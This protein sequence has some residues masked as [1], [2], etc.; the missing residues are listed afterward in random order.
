M[1]VVDGDDGA[2]RRTAQC[3]DAAGFAVRE[4]AS[5]EEALQ[6]ARTERPLVVLSEVRLPGL[7]GYEVC[8]RLKD[9]FDDLP[10][11]FLSADRTEPSDRVA[12][13]LV[14][15]D[16]YL[17]KP[18]VPDE[19][20]ARVRA[21]VRRPASASERTVEARGAAD[22]TRR[23]HEVLRLLAEGLEPADVAERLVISPKTVAGHIEHIL[24]K[25]DVHSRAAAIALAYREGLVTP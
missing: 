1:L 24:K 12:G 11:I 18:Y 19:L 7:S 6:E 20:V 25:L 10:V 2:R 5:G 16:D 3:L 15:A 21:V 13:L 8:R 22:L 14:G 23:E 17:A 4:A 9:D